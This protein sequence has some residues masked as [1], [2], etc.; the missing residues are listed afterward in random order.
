M[1]V[2]FIVNSFVRNKVYLLYLL[3]YFK[4]KTDLQQWH[5]IPTKENPADDASRS[6][7]VA[8]ENSSSRWFQGP[9]FL[10]QKD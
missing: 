9:R 2:L 8:R 6:L 3:T 1:G 5:Y 10:W 4:E 7:N